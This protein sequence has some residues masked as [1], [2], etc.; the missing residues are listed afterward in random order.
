MKKSCIWFYSLMFTVLYSL[1]QLYFHSK[2]VLLL[3]LR[4]KHSSKVCLT[5]VPL[6]LVWLLHIATRAVFNTT[7]MTMPLHY[8]K[9]FIGFCHLYS[10]SRQH[11][12]SS[13]IWPLASSLALSLS[14]VQSKFYIPILLNIIICS[15]NSN[16]SLLLPC[17]GLQVCLH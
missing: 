15:S 1:V 4:I 10:S 14:F 2:N 11:T 8:L 17:P 12:L 9:V 7:Y 3:F 13:M 16:V 5:L 6:P